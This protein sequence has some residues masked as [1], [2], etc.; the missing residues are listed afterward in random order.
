V[1]E[2]EVFRVSTD[3]GVALALERIPARGKAL[4]AAFLAHAM[5]ANRRTLDRP[6][7]A[8]LASRLAAAGVETYVADLRGHGDSG[9]FREWSYDEIV[10]RDLPA[11]ARFVRARHPGVP[12]AG[13]GH[14]LAG[15]GL[16]AALAD[17]QGAL[18]PLDLAVNIAGN[19]WLRGLERSWT[20]WL[21][22]RAAMTL[23]LAIARAVGRIPARALRY[24]SE[25]VSRTFIEEIARWTR[26]GRFSLSDGTDLLAAMPRVETP[27]LAVFGAGDRLLCVPEAGARFHAGLRRLETIVAGRA[28]CGF[29][30]G[31]MEL[32][33]D[34][35]SAP[36][37]EEIARRVARR[38]EE[39]ARA[40]ATAS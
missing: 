11:I 14:S 21:E 38:L 39:A 26:E 24:G 25:D 22:K 27:V 3:D 29:D 31:H 9:P 34:P 18:P 36:L 20:K 1:S 28:L 5:M 15:H 23:S 8:G 40:R 32:V 37:W 4:G 2:R 16:I 6:R 19:A 30:P 7:G 33:T 13:L 17:P 35:R 12:L 10:R